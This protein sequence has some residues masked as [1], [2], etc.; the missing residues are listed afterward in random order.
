MR[1]PNPFTTNPLT[2]LAAVKLV[3]VPA[4][5]ETHEK[6]V[7]L[8]TYLAA[9]GAIEIGSGVSPSPKRP[10][11]ILAALQPASAPETAEEPAAPVP[12][13]FGR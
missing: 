5:P 2:T 3:T 6:R 7:P 8:R 12:P 13:R 10:V 4:A 9:P 11:A 1:Q